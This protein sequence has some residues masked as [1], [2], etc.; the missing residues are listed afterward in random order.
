[1][2]TEQPP[3]RPISA[4]SLKLPPYWPNDPYV[5]FAQVEAQFATRDITSEQ[6]KFSYIIASLQPEIAQEVRDILITP[7]NETPYQHL[8]DELIKLSSVQLRLF[9]LLFCIIIRQFLTI[10]IVSFH[11]R[12]RT[13]INDRVSFK[14]TMYKVLY[15]KVRIKIIIHPNTRGNKTYILT[16]QLIMQHIDLPPQK[17][18]EVWQ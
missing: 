5:W 14:P 16:V 15:W 13:H 4:V 3:P 10:C 8:K 1:M 12:F 6:T 9:S 17:G 2:T 11:C 18:N 7:P